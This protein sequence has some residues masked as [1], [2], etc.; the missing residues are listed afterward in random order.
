MKKISLL[1][2]FLILDVMTV[3][4]KGEKEA[5]KWLGE[6]DFFEVELDNFSLKDKKLTHVGLYE[7]IIPNCDIYLDPKG[8]NETDIRNYVKAFE[9]DYISVYGIS[10]PD[11]ESPFIGEDII[12]SFMG[13]EAKYFRDLNL[14]NR[15]YHEG[16]GQLFEYL[17]WGLDYAV[18]V[19]IFDSAID[20]DIINGFK[21]PA[22]ELFLRLQDAY[23]LPLGYVCLIVD[24]NKNIDSSWL[25]EN[26]CWVPLA[27]QRNPFKKDYRS[28]KIRESIET[29]H[30]SIFS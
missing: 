10:Y 21:K 7:K 23:H 29:V 20:K 3:F 19:H 24:E 6:S 11:S 22:F 17:K 18:L 28:I 8:L 1:T 14:Y 27:N 9:I 13:I 2:L 16:I 5:V 25:N 4:P 30:S 15:K 12:R 26:S